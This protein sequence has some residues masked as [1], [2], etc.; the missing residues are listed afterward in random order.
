MFIRRNASGGVN[1]FSNQAIP[2]VMDEEVA[3]DFPDLAAFMIGGEGNKLTA[4]IIFAGQ[5][6]FTA[7]AVDGV[8]KSRIEAEFPTATQ[9]RRIMERDADPAFFDAMRLRIRA[10]RKEGADFKAGAA[11]P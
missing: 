11:W 8:T 3:D 6:V 1:G 2:G 9:I 5:P 4:P 7:A 10:L